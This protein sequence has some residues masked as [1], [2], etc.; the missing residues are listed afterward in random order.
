[1]SCSIS[2]IIYGDGTSINV[3][4]DSVTWPSQTHACTV[5]IAYNFNT[6]HHYTVYY[7]NYY[8]GY[9]AFPVFFQLWNSGFPK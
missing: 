6:M 1:M 9:N 7:N 3:L 4:H 5:I 8:K 2:S